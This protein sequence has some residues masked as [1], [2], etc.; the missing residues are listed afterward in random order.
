MVPRPTLAG[1]DRDGREVAMIITIADVK[2]KAMIPSADTVYDSAITA[3][4]NEMQGALEYSIA[5]AY[6]NDTSNTALQAVLKLGMLEIITGEFL[7]QL[8]REFGNA[9]QFSIA[10]VTLGPAI[11][12]GVELVQQG[13]ARL[14]PFL[15]AAL[16]E[17]RS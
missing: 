14:A 13:A 2:R 7:E 9:E 15:K 16:M 17:V 5:D 1:A 6:L 4:V 12:C 11:Q 8:R 3:L 10:G